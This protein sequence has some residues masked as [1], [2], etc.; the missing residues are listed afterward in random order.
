MKIQG[1]RNRLYFFKDLGSADN[2]HPI[3]PST[4]PPIYP[5]TAFSWDYIL[6]Q[7]PN[8]FCILPSI[9]LLLQTFS[10]QLRT[11]PN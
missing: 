2:Y 7:N 8:E 4:H 1:L 5:S 11:F 3:H 6:T 10:P 9:F